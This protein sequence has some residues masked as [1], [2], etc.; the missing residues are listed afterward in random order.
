MKCPKCNQD[1]ESNARFCRNCG[2]N[3]PFLPEH[4]T[5]LALVPTS[6]KENLLSKSWWAVIMLCVLLCPIALFFAVRELLSA[7]DSNYFIDHMLASAICLGIAII[8]LVLSMKF[9]RKTKI[10]TMF[11]AF[12]YVQKNTNKQY[13]VVVKDQK[14]GLYNTKR[15]SLCIKCLYD[16]IDW[17]K[18]GETLLVSVDGEN[19]VIDIYGN[20]LS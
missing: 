19:Y 14:F 9:Y 11:S 12:D 18:D 10:V 15:H 13:V 7:S 17:N 6:I 8:T 20:K 1:N 3:L 2:S 16:S 4:H 5:S